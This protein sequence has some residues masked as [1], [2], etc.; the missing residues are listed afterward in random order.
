MDFIKPLYVDLGRDDESA[1]VPEKDANFYHDF[2][3]CYER[4]RLIVPLYSKVRNYLTRKPY[5]TEKYKL[6]FE[7]STL[8]AGWDV[9]RA[10]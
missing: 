10:S 9:N 2:D 6:N 5:K 3:L 4:L 1:T 8:L 7:N